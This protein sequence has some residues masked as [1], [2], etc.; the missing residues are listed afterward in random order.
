MGFDGSVFWR[1]VQHSGGNHVFVPCALLK[2]LLDYRS[3]IMLIWLLLLLI[4]LIDCLQGLAMDEFACGKLELTGAELTGE[5][6]EALSVCQ[7]WLV[8]SHL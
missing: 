8:G 6:E 5:R 7:D 3:G 4:M 2:G 1:I